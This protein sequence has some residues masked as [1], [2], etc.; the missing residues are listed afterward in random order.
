[1]PAT[2]NLKNKTKKRKSPDPS[3]TGPGSGPS[4]KMDLAAAAVGAVLAVVG[5]DGDLLPPGSV[6]KGGSPASSRPDPGAL[7]LDPCA[8]SLRLPAP[9]LSALHP[10]VLPLLALTARRTRGRGPSLRISLLPPGAPA[11]R[12]IYIQRERNGK[13]RAPARPRE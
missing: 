8:P 7:R 10:A 6:T 4:S 11:A 13:E 9:S 1:M 2:V 3:L 12:A 5:V